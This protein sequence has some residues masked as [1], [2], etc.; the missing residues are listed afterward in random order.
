MGRR[1]SC[2]AGGRGTPWRIPPDEAAM[3]EPIR[4]GIVGSRFAA[5]FH[6]EGYQRVYGVPVQVVGVTSR[7]PE[8][9]ANFAREHQVAAFDSLAQLCEACDVI[10]LCS[11]PSTHEPLAIEAFSYGK[12]V[13]IEKPF[14]GFYGPPGAGDGFRGDSF[15]KETMLREA[16]A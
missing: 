10:D 16:M 8:S 12:H 6:W 1:R 5:R 13:V 4:V 2:P 14:T 15:S 7:S 11:P 3:P 9:A